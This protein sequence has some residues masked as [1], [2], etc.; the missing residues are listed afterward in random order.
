VVVPNGVRCRLGL[1]YDWV[2]KGEMYSLPYPPTPMEKYGYNSNAFFN[3]VSCELDEDSPIFTPC[4]QP[5]SGEDQGD[6]ENPEEEDQR[7][8]GGE[9]GG[10]G[11]DDEI[12]N[13]FFKTEPDEEEEPN[14]EEFDREEPQEDEKE[15]EDINDPERRK[16][17]GP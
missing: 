12:D 7:G 4:P 1:K 2:V 16:R 10:E 15:A 6:P 5:A 13:P 14:V 11:G 8:E 9:E 3:H 17:I